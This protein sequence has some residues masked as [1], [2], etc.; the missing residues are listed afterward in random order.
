MG[1]WQISELWKNYLF[2][3]TRHLIGE[4]I[5]RCGE[6]DWIPLPAE[7]AGGCI[8]DLRPILEGKN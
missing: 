6:A 3:P 5:R 8:M 7:A 2:C 1:M 4:E